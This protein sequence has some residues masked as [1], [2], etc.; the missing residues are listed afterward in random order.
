M[1]VRKKA[2]ELFESLNPSQ[3]RWI[4]A[5]AAWMREQEN[6]ARAFHL[7]ARLDGEIPKDFDPSDLPRAL[8]LHRTEPTIPAFLVLDE[9]DALLQAAESLVSIIRDTLIPRAGEEGPFSPEDVSAEPNRQIE[10][11]SEGRLKLLYELLG[12][13]GLSFD[14]EWDP[15]AEEI[16]SVSFRNRDSFE[17]FYQFD[18]DLDAYLDEKHFSASTTEEDSPPP[19]SQE[20]L[21]TINPIFTSHTDHVDE[22][23]CFVLMPFGKDWSDGIYDTLEKILKQKNLDA[24]RADD[25]H[26]SFI[27]EDIWTKINQAGLIIADVTDQNPNVMYELGIAHTVGKPMI[28]IT[29]DVDTIPFDFQHLRHYEYSGPA[30]SE[31]LREQ[32][33]PAI[34]E[35]REEWRNRDDGELQMKK[36][37]SPIYMAAR[38]GFGVGSGLSGGGGLLG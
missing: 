21:T 5:A 28:L 34:D 7:K 16:A 35:V 11:L 10:E 26:G 25:S 6:S 33:P 20:Q 27:M 9:D 30:G 24:V 2:R 36:A 15:E 1:I 4:E 29:Q 8:I 23:M 18:G 13:T 37:K 31:Q 3:Q 19:P 14:Y 32:L 12:R 38:R 17:P 22:S